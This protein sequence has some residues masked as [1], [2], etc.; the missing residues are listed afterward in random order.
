MKNLIILFLLS[1]FLA[2]SQSLG[3][4]FG[5]VVSTLKYVKDGK[6][7]VGPTIGATYHHDFGKFQLGIEPSYTTK[8]AAETVIYTDQTGG[9]I[10][11][12]SNIKFNYIEAPITFGYLPVNDKAIFGFNL[13]VSPGYLISSKSHP[14]SNYSTIQTNKFNFDLL[15]GIKAGLKLSDNLL[16]T[17]NVRAG[18]CLISPTNYN[19][20]SSFLNVEYKF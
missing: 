19:Y 7:L 5:T 6:P 9:A 3:L 18:H 12:K 20:V 1:P 14:Y 15:V 13:G 10:R 4:K 16:L 8:G 2:Y 17:L 11:E